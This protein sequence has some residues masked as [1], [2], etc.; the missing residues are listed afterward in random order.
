MGAVAG[1]LSTRWVRRPVAGLAAAFAL[2][3]ISHIPMDAIPHSDYAGL[4]RATMVA[5]VLSEIV[6]AGG[7]VA[8]MLRRG[9][10]A[11]DLPRSA[12]GVIGACLPDFKFG[13]EL[14]LPPQLARQAAQLA[15]RVHFFHARAPES[16]FVA[17][18]VEV[19]LTLVL[20]VWLWRATQ[21]R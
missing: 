3:L 8:W 20:F 11:S 18:M 5:L 19:V 2:G 4:S 14:L 13:A 16:R 15:E 12:A 6:I 7:L 9:R 21:D 17:L 1:V 10:R